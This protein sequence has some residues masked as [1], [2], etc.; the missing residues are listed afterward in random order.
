MHAGIC[1]LLG[2][3]ALNGALE[4]H[5][6]RIELELIFVSFAVLM[7]VIW[8]LVMPGRLGVM[9]VAL[10]PEFWL[11]IVMFTF[12]SHLIRH[13]I[14]LVCIGF[15]LWGVAVYFLRTRKTYLTPF[16]YETLRSH[17]CDAESPERVARMDKIAGHTLAEA[18]T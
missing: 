17:L 5:V 7:P 16:T 1:V 10:K 2:F 4:G 18:S 13:E 15:N 12:F 11:Q 3:V 9:V 6:T 14:L 8:A